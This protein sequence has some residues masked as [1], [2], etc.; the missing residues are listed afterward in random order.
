MASGFMN[1]LSQT[2]AYGD[3]AQS[4]NP[5]LKFVDW[6]R[7]LLNVPV[8][9]PKCEAFSVDPL[10]TLS[11]F[12]GV[13]S[14]TIDGT[15]PFTLSLSSVP[16]SSNLYRM[17]WGGSGTNPSLRTKRTLVLGSTTVTV[18]VNGNSTVTFADSVA[19][20]FVNVVVG[21]VLFVPGT[22]TGDTAG[23]FNALN[24]GEWTVLSK[25]GANQILTLARP[26]GK[27]FEGY[28]EVVAVA[29]DPQVIAYT[30]TGVQ[31]G[32]KVTISDGFTAPVTSTFEVASV[33][34]SYFEFYAT[35]ALPVDVTA[36]PTVAGMIFYTK[37]KR[38]MQ[39]D[40]DQECLV[41]VNGD[42]GS[43]QRLSPWAAGDPSQMGSYSKSG[44]AW[45]LSVQNL[46]TNVM[47]IV[48]VSIE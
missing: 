10:S 20:K 23:P 5:A 8:K 7:Q 4:N 32:D 46:S 33:R 28:G 24:E 2:V 17:T 42:S 6:T 45:S 47:S 15:A 48:V 37:G 19:G 35:Q 9:N 25:D 12:S 11:V 27:S 40:A 26:T 36:S 38:Y 16:G 41:L 30:S 3:S 13:R 1:L 29:S 22:T 44:P 34:P 21:D 14:T 31:V 43:T 18:T 39:V